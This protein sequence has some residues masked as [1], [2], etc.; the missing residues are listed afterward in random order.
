MT[1]EDSGTARRVLE[2]AGCL[3]T[4]WKRFLACIASGEAPEEVTST[5]DPESASYG[6]HGRRLFQALIENYDTDP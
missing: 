5:S 6:E 2:A 1:E 4:S 3:P